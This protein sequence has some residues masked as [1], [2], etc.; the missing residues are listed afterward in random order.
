MH[1]GDVIMQ[2]FPGWNAKLKWLKE[3]EKMLMIIVLLNLEPEGDNEE[4]STNLLLF[5]SALMLFQRVVLSTLCFCCL[6]TV[7]LLFHC[8]SSR[9]NHQASS[10]GF[11]AGRAS[12]SLPTERTLSLS[13]SY[14]IIANYYNL[15]HEE[16][17]TLFFFI[18]MKWHQVLLS[19]PW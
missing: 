16:F 3:V 7:L 15:W 8:E 11:S 13:L 12:I 14:C 1:S 18:M 19:H 4:R 5:N 2:N 10:R 17:S 9:L 6:S